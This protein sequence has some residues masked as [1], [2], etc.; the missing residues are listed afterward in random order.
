[1]GQ[2]FLNC[3][4]KKVLLGKTQFGDAQKNLGWHCPRMP[5]CGY[6]PAFYT[7]KTPFVTATATKMCFFGSNSQ[8]Y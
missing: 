2:D 8:V 7:P 3:M 1:M 6:R 4:F 5:P